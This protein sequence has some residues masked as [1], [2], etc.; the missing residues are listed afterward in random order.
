MLRELIE[1]KTPAVLCVRNGAR[2][3]ENVMWMSEVDV[4]WGSCRSELNARK[5]WV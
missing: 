2:E 4:D 5:E 1:E 3:G